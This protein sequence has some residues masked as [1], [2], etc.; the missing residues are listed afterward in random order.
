[1]RT[2]RR[3]GQWKFPAPPT[4]PIAACP[5]PLLYCAFVARASRSPGG[6]LHSSPSCYRPVWGWRGRYRLV[7]CLVAWRQR[8]RGRNRQRYARDGP[9]SAVLGGRHRAPRRAEAPTLT[10]RFTCRLGKTRPVTRQCAALAESA[11][12]RSVLPARQ[13]LR[14]ATMNTASPSNR[15][16]AT[17]MARLCIASS[18]KSHQT[19]A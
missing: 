3:A 2:R 6:L 11:S 18:A 10:C 15:L 12:G 7:Y 5:A 4:V 9:G 14:Y 1:M 17:P 19:R 13:H 8:G 16:A